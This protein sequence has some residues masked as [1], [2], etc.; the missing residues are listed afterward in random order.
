MKGQIKIND[1]ISSN[2]I[3]DNDNN[4]GSLSNSNITNTNSNNVSNNGTNKNKKTTTIEIT[5]CFR[6]L[7][8]YIFS[9]NRLKNKLSEG[10]FF[11]FKFTPS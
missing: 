3:I 8:T 4:N 7:T 9:S 1:D 11:N 5:D 10:N 2:D 6:L